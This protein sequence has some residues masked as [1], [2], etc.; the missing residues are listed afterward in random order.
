MTLHRKQRKA[1]SFDWCCTSVGWCST[2]PVR[3]PRRRRGDGET[4][5]G[6]TAEPLR[7]RNALG[8]RRGLH[9]V[10]KRVRESD[11]GAGQMSGHLS[12][13][14]LIVRV[15]G[16]VISRSVRRS[17]STER[18][19]MAARSPQGLAEEAAAPAAAGA[20]RASRSRDTSEVA[21]EVGRVGAWEVRSAP[22]EAGGIHTRAASARAG[23]LPKEVCEAG[24]STL[25]LFPGP[26]VCD[27]RGVR[28]VQPENSRGGRRTSLK[29]RRSRATNVSRNERRVGCSR[30]QQTSECQRVTTKCAVMRHPPPRWLH[31]HRSPSGQSVDGCVRPTQRLR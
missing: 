20:R 29:A 30:R 1:T 6:G 15:E 22:G 10:V 16:W 27:W 9:L 21:P 31:G 8:F 28:M 13:S 23:E 3:L 11:R 18:S 4:L 5:T 7:H 24:T 14:V 19:F 12:F 25:R 2:R 17:F 26:G